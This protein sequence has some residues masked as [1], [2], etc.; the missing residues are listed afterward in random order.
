MPN[1]PESM[2]TIHLALLRNV[3]N[4]PEIRRRLIEA[5]KAEGEVGDKLREEVDF[6]FLEASMLVSRQHLLIAILNTLLSSLPSPDSSLPRTS[7]HNLH[8]ELLLHLSPNN[9]I[10]DSLR[11]HGISDH[12]ATLLVVRLGSPGPSEEIW[13]KIEHVVRGQLVSLDELNQG[14]IV[15][16][17]RVDKVSSCSLTY[18]NDT[19]DRFTS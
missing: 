9:N 2:N 5:S 8:S 6:A 19:H 11:H 10:T 3:T 7:T 13:D 16:W 17:Q 18:G 12:T 1:F 14:E 4:S 15:D